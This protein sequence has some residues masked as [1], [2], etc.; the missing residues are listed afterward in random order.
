MGDFFGDWLKQANEFASSLRGLCSED[1]RISAVNDGVKWY[2]NNVDVNDVSKFVF[3]PE[4][5]I[6]V[7]QPEALSINWLIIA[8]IILLVI[9]IISVLVWFCVCRKSPSTVDQ[10]ADVVPDPPVANMV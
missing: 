6:C 1:Q 5:G 9:A 3:D 10:Q 2:H 8:P 4:S 7:I